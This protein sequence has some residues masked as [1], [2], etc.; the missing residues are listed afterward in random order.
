MAGVDP[1]GD[2]LLLTLSFDASTATAGNVFSFGVAANRLVETCAT[3]VDPCVMVPDGMLTWS[4]GT[5]TAM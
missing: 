2:D 3:A 5:M 1:T 4:G